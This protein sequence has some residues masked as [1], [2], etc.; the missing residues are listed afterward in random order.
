MSLPLL[1]ASSSPFR[2]TLLKK[3]AINF[4]S[5]SPDIDEAHKQGE[6]ARQ[7]VQRLAFEKA[8]ALAADYPSHLI[9]GSDQVCVID[10]QILGKPSDYNTALAQLRQAS[11][12]RVRFYTGLSLHNS[13]TGQSETLVDTFDV[14]FRTL[15]DALI[16]RYLRL[17]QPYGCAGSFKSE[18]AGIVLFERLE[19]KD[20]N[21]L[22]GLPLID[23]IGLLE[24]QGVQ[25][26]GNAID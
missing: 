17:E 7:L 22:V 4:T 23:L 1:L 20:P 18:G 21:T 19:G 24:R 5:A 26:P 25:V 9:I 10:E 15:D 13:A 8:Q 3:L 11:G 16:E 12:K 2:Q 14:V 6:S